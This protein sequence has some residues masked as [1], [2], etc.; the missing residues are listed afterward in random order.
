MQL[1]ENERIRN[2]NEKS[3]E[4][5]QIIKDAE[6]NREKMERQHQ[7]SQRKLLLEMQKQHQESQKQLIESR[8]AEAESKKRLAQFSEILGI[9]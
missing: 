8:S 5:Q 4:L 9:S 1:A 2:D 6:R 7:E 3:W